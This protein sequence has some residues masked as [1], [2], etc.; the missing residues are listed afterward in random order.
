MCSGNNYAALFLA[1]S[2]AIEI[3]SSGKNIIGEKYNLTCMVM[4]NGSSDKPSIS[5][6]GTVSSN[7]SHDN[8]IYLSVLQFDPLQESHRGHY[9]C[10]VRVADVAEEVLQFNLT[11]LGNSTHQNAQCDN[12]ILHY[13]IQY[14]KFMPLSMA[15]EVFQLQASP[16]LYHVVSVEM[17]SLTHLIST[18]GY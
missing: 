7:I 18:N 14:H 8:G 11:V 13:I 16:I 3:I 15:V 4:I 5:W 1:A 2:K 9:Q 10:S 12:S 17:K 6:N